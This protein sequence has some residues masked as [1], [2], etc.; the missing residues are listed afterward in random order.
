MENDIINSTIVKGGKYMKKFITTISLQGK[1]LTP[2]AYTAADNDELKNDIAVSFPILVAV[3]NFVNEGENI[4]ISPIVINSESS[5]RNYETFKN[6][7]DEIAKKKSFTYELRPIEKDLGDTIDV[8]IG[9]FSKLI[10]TVDDNDDLYTCVTY[11]TKPISV[12]TIMA[13]NYAY[14]VKHNVNINK[15]VYGSGTWDGSKI[16]DVTPLFYIDSAVNNLAK[17]NLEN[18]EDALRTILG[19]E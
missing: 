18:P 2:I 11:G 19:L 6:E 10:G 15:I 14:K 9:L 4:I 12:L 1:D 13:L 16:Y 7:L 5:N 8:M 3:N 17:L